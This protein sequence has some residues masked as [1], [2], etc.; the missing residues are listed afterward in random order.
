MINNKTVVTKKERVAYLKQTLATNEKWALK[1]I[2]TIYRK[3][4]Y[5]EMAS[6]SSTENNGVGFTGTDA[7]ILTSL[8][9]QF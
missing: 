1:A 9:K 2:G 3:Q 4:T 5:A 7:E 6:N 8:M